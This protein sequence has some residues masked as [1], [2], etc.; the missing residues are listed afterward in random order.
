MSAGTD[1]DH[2]QGA[3]AVSVVIPT[4]NRRLLL[5]TTLTGVLAQRG[6]EVV[7]V[8][9]DDGSTD[10]TAGAVSALGDPRVR[11]LR[12]ETSQGVVAARNRGLAAA[13][14]DWVAFCDD[15]DVWSPDK[16]VG[17]I[18]AAARLGRAWAVAGAVGFEPDGTILYTRLPVEGKQLAATL[19]WNNAVP[20]GSSNVVARRA[21]LRETGGFDPRLRVL[22]D[23]ELWIRLARSGP[24]ASVAA[25]VVG[26]RMHGANMSTRSE[27]VLDELCLIEQRSADLRN[28]RR[29]D[30]AWFHQ[31]MGVSM[32][33]G[34]DRRGAA[35]AFW[36]Q[37]TVRHPAPALRALG[38]L[39]VPAS[40]WALARRLKN[41][42]ADPPRTP[43]WLADL[44]D[45][46]R[47]RFVTAGA[48]E[49]AG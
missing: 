22:A 27:G 28:G 47:G 2:A 24:P 14:G 29:L 11:V 34:G 19:P 40:G 17:Q 3:G 30:P 44:L 41:S 46:E 12:H 49:P 16:L 36:R 42:R 15:D 37:V 18:D 25:P 48:G 9:V 20:G 39:V 7:V 32:M 21:L 26:Y 6:V 38:C 31:W 1:G 33:R 4:K 10:G 23:W 8:V 5:M 43:P 45:E 35:G 13:R